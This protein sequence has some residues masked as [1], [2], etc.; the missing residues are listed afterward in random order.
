[1]EQR[2]S[3][4]ER[5]GRG[6]WE[7]HLQ[8]IKGVSSNAVAISSSFISLVSSLFSY[9]PHDRLSASEVLEHPFLAVG[10]FPLM[11]V[12]PEDGDD[13]DGSRPTDILDNIEGLGRQLPQDGRCCKSFYALIPGVVGQS[14]H[15]GERHQ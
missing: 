10:S 13:F 3:G 15:A 8:R 7:R 1:M 5:K 4:G 11:G 14:L 6:A 2:R 9:T 12:S